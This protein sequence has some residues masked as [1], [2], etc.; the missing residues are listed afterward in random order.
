M[1]AATGP[2]L[3]PGASIF[4]N[5]N[6]YPGQ[7][8]SPLARLMISFDDHS[9]SIPTWIDITIK[10]RSFSVKRGRSGKLDQF[11]AGNCEL[12]LDNRARQFDPGYASSP[13]YPNVRPMN[14]IW[15]YAEHAG[16]CL[17]LFHGYVDTWQQDWPGGGWSD[18]IV[19]LTAS[20]EFKVLSLYSLP[21]SSP[22]RESYEGLVTSDN[23]VG[24]WSFNELPS[25]RIEPSSEQT[26][27]GPIERLEGKP[28]RLD[29]RIPNLKRW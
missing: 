25:T 20:D 17:D 22:P 18:A 8:N 27:L 7:G 12:V 23:P 5:T 9:V 28:K 10:L 4:P 1:A 15:L 6:V 11:N 21:V 14:R 13:Y 3:W 16:E 2:P 26:I 24:Y 19:T 29:R